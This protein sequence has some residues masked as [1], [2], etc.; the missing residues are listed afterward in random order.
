[1]AASESSDSL[2]LITMPTV[3]QAVR[4]TG[5]AIFAS[6]RRSFK[7]RDRICPRVAAAFKTYGVSLTTWAGSNTSEATASWP[8]V[9]Q[10]LPPLR[11]GLWWGCHA[12]RFPWGT[13]H[14]SRFARRDPPRKGGGEESGGA[15]RVDFQSPAPALRFAPPY[16][17]TY[18]RMED[19]ATWRRGRPVG[20]RDQAASAFDAVGPFLTPVWRAL[21][22]LAG[23]PPW[24]E[25][26]G[27]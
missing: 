19:F 18:G 17:A 13:P 1:M 23:G 10:C 11:G 7:N 4:A 9:I 24:Y 26:V 3:T 12:G 14:P 6:S 15:L 5:M 20:A 22:R 27:P 25:P 21:R 2:A 16:W 8:H